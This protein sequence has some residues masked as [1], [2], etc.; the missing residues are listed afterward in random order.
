LQFQGLNPGNF[1]LKN[2]G[3]IKHKTEAKTNKKLQ[4]EQ[5]TQDNSIFLDGKMV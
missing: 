1:S 3:K 4:N 2:S 5:K